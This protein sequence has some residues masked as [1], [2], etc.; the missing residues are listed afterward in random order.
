MR[1]NETGG[2]FRPYVTTLALAAS[3]LL[4]LAVS[5]QMHGVEG[6]QWT[7]LGGDAGHTRYTP[8]DQI[9][10]FNFE[11]LEI[12]WEF[13]AS[14]FGPSTSRATPS[15]IGDKLITVTGDRRH[16]IALEPNTGQ[17]LWSY[18]EPKTERW[19]YS[20]RKAYG[21]GISYGEIDGRG[22]VFIISP[23]FFLTALDAETGLPLEDWGE[24]VPIRGFPNTGVVDLLKPIIEDWGPWKDA[25]LE[26]DPDQGLPL[27]LGYI[28]SSSPPIV[29]DDVVVIGNSAEQG[30]N[31][32]RIENVPGDILGF[33]ARTGDFMWKFNV[34]PR[35]GEFGHETWENDAW[36]WTG[37]V[38][39]WAPLSADPELGLVYVPTNPPTIDYYG[40]FAPGDNLFSTSVFA[41][42]VHTGERRW[43][44]QLVHHDVWNYDTPTAPLLMDVTVDGERIPGLF[45]ATKQGWVYAFNRETGEPIWPIE[46]REVLPSTVPG[47]KL[48]PTQ[49][50]PTKPEPFELQGR[51]EKDLIDYTPELR[52]AALEHAREHDLITPFFNPPVVSD[53]PEGQAPWAGLACPGGGGGANIY[54][55]TAADPTSGILF[56]AS[57]SGCSATRLAPGKDSPLD[58]PE[59]TGTTRSD[60]SNDVSGG[61]RGRGGGPPYGPASANRG[62]IDGLSIWKGPVGRV[63]A[64]DMNTGDKLW[65]IPN[66]DSPEQIQESIRNHPL[67]QGNPA[68]PT[69]IG[70]QGSAV[71]TVTPTLLF[72]SGQTS[73]GQWNIFAIDKMTGERLGAVP[74]P[75]PTRYGLSSWTY[76]GKQYII[77]Q[78]N[79]GLVAMALP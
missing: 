4:P 26:Y 13:D 2:R 50:Y 62:N 44:Y 17:L 54:S 41:L 14:S 39:S 56:V 35:P 9:T 51:Q 30:Y 72:A 48:S 59:M 27:E 55:P 79:D 15:L 74:I 57:G 66:G 22:I 43:H 53:S 73:D 42:D 29:V 11:D 37:D 33:D 25:G 28:T 40:G 52:A 3:L 36:R 6:G 7:Y 46:E 58:G 23:A 32:T 10:P 64:Y 70:R 47:E 1:K 45:Q 78:Q 21:K 60:W 18:S 71:L 34:I 24:H 68:V 49:P 16:V 65:T 12:A 75:G 8:S 61:G 20:M 31:Q 67:V 63:V 19:D 77:V 76:E 5:A 69:N 38:S